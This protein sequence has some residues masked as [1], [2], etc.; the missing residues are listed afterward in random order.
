MVEDLPSFVLNL[1][2]FVND[3]RCYIILSHSVPG[4]SV[5]LS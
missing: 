4:G 3:L 2:Q 1:Q 5:R